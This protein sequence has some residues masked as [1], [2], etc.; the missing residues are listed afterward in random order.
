[1][2]VLGS[3]QLKASNH[4]SYFPVNPLNRM[5]SVLLVNNLLLSTFI[6]NSLWAYFSFQILPDNLN[7]TIDSTYDVYVPMFVRLPEP[8]RFRPQH[9]I[10]K[11]RNKYRA[12]S[13]RE[14]FD[15]DSSGRTMK[16]RETFYNS[17][18]SPPFIVPIDDYLDNRRKQIQ[19]RIWDSLSTN[20]DL[21][22]ALSGNDL[23]RMISQATGLSIPIPPNPLTNIFGKPEINLN[24]TGDVNL[25]VGW[26]FDSQ[27]L[28][29]V[30]A[31]G[32]TQ[33]SPVFSQDIKINVTGGIGDKFKIGTNWNTRNQFEYE[34]LFKMGYEGE[35][36]EIIRL[37]EVGNVNLP[38]PSTLI[39]GGQSLFGVRADFQFGPLFIKT[40][41]SQK[42]GE[43]KFVDV[44]GGSSKQQFQLRAYDWAKNHFFLDTAY[45]T[46]YNDY[47]KY[48]TPVIPQSAGKH[49]VKEIE[50]WESSTEV[51]NTAFGA[52]GVAF[53]DLEGKKL[54]QNQQYD[55][56]L[57][58]TAIKTGEVE[59]A[60]F[61]KLDSMRYKVDFNLGTIT[62]TNLRQDRYYAVAYRI[63][64]ETL[65]PDDDTYY[66]TFSTLVNPKDTVILKLIYRPNMLTAY[67]TLW[68]RQMKNIYSINATNASIGERGIS[69]W[70]INQSNDST[71]ILPG[72]P[73]K[74]VTILKVDQVNNSTGSPPPDGLFDLRPP[75]YNAQYGEITFPSLE[76]FRL[77]IRDYFTKQGSP[78]LSNQFEYPQIYDTTYDAARRATDKDRFVIS[79][80][81]SG[82]ASNRISLGGFNIPPG[83]VRVT[84][85]GAPLREFEDYVIDYYS[86]MLTIRN[87]RATLPNANLRI[88]YEQQDIFNI[89][90]RTLVG[91]RADYILAKKRNLSAFLGFTA[92]LY[93]QSAVIDR[94]RLGDEPVSNSMFGFDAK[95]NWNAPFIT[96][97]LDALPFFDTKTESSLNIG[98]EWAM[99]LPTPNKRTSE[100]CYDNNMPVV[101]LDDFEGAQKYVSLGLS[102]FQW[103]HASIPED[104]LI[105]S[106]DT[107]VSLYRGKT[108]WWQNFIP[109]LSVTDP[110]PNRQTIQ[111]RS[112]ISPLYFVFNPYE[113]G[114]YNRN[115]E[116]RDSANP[117]FKADSADIFFNANKGK[118]WGGFQRLLSSFNTNFDNENI[119]YIEVMMQLN[120]YEPGKT[121]M[122]IDLGMI[123][124]DI[125]PDKSNNTEDGITQASPLPNGII[126]LNEDLGLDG[127]K[128]ETENDPTK[129]PWPL[130]LEKDPSK[131]NY[132]F[133]FTKDDYQRNEDDFRFYNNYEG[134][135]ISEMGQFP[136]QEVLNKNN[137][138][139]ISLDD[140]YYT[141]EIKLDPNPITNP[142]IVGGNPSKDWFLYRIPVRKPHRSTGN[143][144]FANIQYVRVWFKGGLFKATIAD[145]RLVGSHWQRISANPNLPA[146]RD[147]VMQVSFVNREENANAPD[148]YTMPPCVSPP[149]QL[150]N[151]DP[152]QD[153]RLNEQSLALSVKN[154]RY[155]DERYA[156][157]FI[158][159]QDVFFYKRLKFFVHGDGQMPANLVEGAPVKAF[160][161]LRF[162]VDSLNYYEYRTPVI[163]GWQN[164]D[165]DLLQ[166]TGIKQIRDSN[167]L[168]QTFPVPGNPYAMYAIRGN[169]IL[170]RVQYFAFGIAN[171]S[172]A[173]PN[174]L[175]TNI[176][177]DELR[178]IDPESSKDWGAVG[179]IEL[180][181]ADLGTINANISHTEPNF[182]KLEE[183][184][185]SRTATTNM[186][187]TVVAALDK[188]APK[189][190]KEFKLPLSYTHSEFTQRPQFQSNNDVNLRSAAQASYQ[191]AIDK[192]LTA[193]Q[194]QEEYDRTIRTSQTVRV[195]D[196]WA[197]TDVRLG[198]P[199]NFFLFKEL[200]NKISLGYSYS[201]EFERNYL[202]EQKFNWRWNLQMQYANNIPTVL[203]VSPL[204]WAG[205]IDVLETYS[206]WKLNFLPSS[207]NFSLNMQRGRIT[208][209]SR[210]LSFPSPVIR[211]F[212]SQRQMQFSWKISDNGFLNPLWDYNVNTTS[213]LVNLELTPEG[214]QRTGSEIASRMFFNEGSLIDFGE[215]TQ[216]TQI[217]TINFKP[218][219]PFGKVFSKFFESNG[220]YSTTYN[221][222][223]P[224]QPDKAIADIAKQATWTNAIRYSIN[225]K[226]KSFGDQ[227][228]GITDPKM[229]FQKPARDTTPAAL[230][231][232]IGRII[233]SIF[234]DWE[235]FKIDFNQNN[236]TI[237]PGVYGSTGFTNFWSGLVGGADDMNNGASLPYQLGLLAD[238]HGSFDVL[239]SP[240][241]PFF[242]V[243]TYNGLRPPNAVLQDNYNQ[244]TSLD[245][246]T[247][248]TLWEGAVLDLNWRTEFAYNR[249]Q[250]VLTD[251]G[252]NPQFTNVIKMESVN[253]TIL[254]L[255]SFFGFN[256]FN[257][258]IENVIDLYNVEA[259]RIT[260][261][262]LDTVTRNQML[263]NALS[264]SLRNG[265]E[266]FSLFGGAA[267]NFLPAINWQ[268]RWDG[269]EKWG[270]F[271][272]IG[273]RRISFEHKYQ[274]RY[275]ENAMT[276]DNGKAIQQQLVQHGFQPLLGLTLSF[277]EKKL[278][279]ILTGNIRYS[280]T[281]QYMLS[282]ANRSTITRQNSDEFQL[283]AS[284]TL[285]GFKFKLLNISLENDL[286]FSFL[287]S[288]KK[289]SRATYDVLNYAGENGRKL[290]GNTQ[291]KIEPR[292]RYSIS[293]RLTASAFVSYEA[294]LTEGAASP[295][296]STTQ[297]GID[298]RLSIAGG[299]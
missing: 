82:T 143:P 263:N 74:L 141:Y 26:R 253:R 94:V 140:S 231:K 218:R 41:A 163:Q 239:S 105:A 2:F 166:L 273:A 289:N 275:T 176:W 92:M 36:D 111:G 96:K 9:E 264:N 3:T 224:M 192:G 77:G 203:E 33:S 146:D 88:E 124:E 29:T 167:N 129:M 101:Y 125:I 56:N 160:V 212:T 130:Y 45:R 178:L 142:Q 114:I 161:F 5:P 285:K 122:F 123:S 223:N 215:N 287:T 78:Q 69:L 169:P 59:K 288:I 70:Y 4:F 119:E 296:F 55:P 34:N 256:L 164:I 151:P 258:T 104:S 155:G 195:L 110:Y 214:R 241:F 72:A 249:N 202:Y 227:L 173:Y 137:G 185:G 136:D 199:V 99:M 10:F 145:W 31:F 95:M 250:T 98:G 66:G 116:Y 63:E 47:Y 103:T 240:S 257:N 278:K 207:I 266:A 115:P 190:F 24:V 144:S 121:Q 20:Y 219:F 165:I 188:F 201:Q 193:Q 6:Q 89:S 206:E 182:H 109:R 255:P 128:D 127:M 297:V 61:M 102:P 208:E 179:N 229:A 64:G 13:Y 177:V 198:I 139:T 270:M 40:I 126:D 230:G 23:A 242:T 171:P 251:A 194:A 156:A 100:I 290:D 133:E 53:A 131:D 262:G 236:S 27:N 150:N 80:E 30:S 91:M 235:S 200:L 49:R 152:N 154:L 248:R 8:Y 19:Y 12:D 244:K 38:V 221:W 120:A 211:N 148:Y 222:F 44:R 284:Y 279:G 293:S 48:S 1:L 247:S 286:E 108:F 93:D 233:K 159:Q 170:T 274:S 209:Q 280:T 252:G 71:D 147:S 238:P 216:H 85:D 67:R 112:N 43:K 259:T 268:L 243:K 51:T 22:A 107:L 168:R 183:R 138:Q 84:L 191:K 76:P 14:Y 276:T 62:I 225:L 269:I 58:N 184:F 232:S 196:N 21:A 175:T 57:K 83:S 271:Q 60:V 272:A 295:G 75:F 298:L 106:S 245:M 90:T 97:L 65:E 11:D 172:Q 187:V 81:V 277:D 32:Q 79:G 149:R 17:E 174:E 299:R 234:L 260:G 87:Q 282:S 37:I 213:S 261:M 217:V 210:F 205:Q 73:D 189:S 291:I 181:L 281:N 254:T 86:G 292:A 117:E 180:K 246:R 52:F 294:T 220:S 118:L 135:A 39:G 15:I 228:F 267:A 54:K 68:L 237:N 197:L 186:N 46:I 35:D 25:R 226:L 204:K 157:R 28:G 7:P 265:M 134:N 18:I 283:Q 16:I 50:V 162:G 132:K 113:R 42:R 158:R 153:I